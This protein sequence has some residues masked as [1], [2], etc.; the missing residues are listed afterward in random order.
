MHSYNDNQIELEYSCP[1]SQELDLILELYRGKLFCHIIKEF[2]ND[3]TKIL[4]TKI[5]SI[6]KS[7]PRTLTNLLS[8]WMFNLY[9]SENFNSLLDPFLPNNFNEINTLKGTLKD[10]DNLLYLVIK[11]WPQVEFMTS[12]ELG[13]LIKTTKR[14]FC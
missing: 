1:Q 12:T 13:E 6:K 11:K 8:S 14:S 2:I 7:F 5:F 3:A 9:A 10:L 4:G